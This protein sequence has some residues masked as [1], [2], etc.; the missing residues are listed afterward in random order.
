MA[1]DRRILQQALQQ[2]GQIQQGA[3]SGQGFDPRGGYGVALAQ[4]ATAGIGAFAQNRARKQLAELEAKEQQQF[5]QAFPQFASIAPQTTAETRQAAI[6]AQLAGQIGSQFKAPDAPK[7]QIKETSK[8]FVRIDP[9]SGQVIPL[10]SGTGESLQPFS[11]PTTNITVGGE[12]PPFRKE[13]EK[14]LGT[15]VAERISKIRTDADNAVGILSNLD[16]IEESLKNIK[17][18]GPLDAPKIFINNL[19]AQLG[20]DIDLDETASLEKINA[21]A[22]QLSVPLVKQ[23]GV[24]PTDRDAKIIEATVSGLGKSKQAN[25]DIIDISRQIAKKKLAHARIAED[26]RDRGEEKLIARKIREYDINNPI[27]QPQKAVEPPRL[28]DGKLDVSKLKRGTTYIRGNEIFEFD[29][30]GFVKK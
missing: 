29:G 19:G 28:P 4:I 13:L 23:L 17:T 14:K 10:T 24:N 18:T 25:I 9:A 6:Q 27:K 20:L 11:Q 3:A 5:A 22:K 21:A 8:G 15:D 2:A 30:I 7:F 1:V 16:T 26:L 12:Q